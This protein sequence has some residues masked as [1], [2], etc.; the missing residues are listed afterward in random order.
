MCQYCLTSPCPS[1]CPN[2]EEPD[3]EYICDDCHCGIY[4]EDEFADINGKRY[5][6]ECLEE[7]S[8]KKLMALLGVDV[9]TA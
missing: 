3:P 8:I 1:G 6:L 4:H 9:S 2:F 5:H 7:M